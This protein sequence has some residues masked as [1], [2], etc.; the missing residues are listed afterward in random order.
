MKRDKMDCSFGA[1]SGLDLPV[2]PSIFGSGVLS[3][4]GN[5]IRFEASIS[6]SW[7][8]EFY[9]LACWKVECFD[10]FMFRGLHLIGFEFRWIQFHISSSL[11]SKCVELLSLL[12]QLVMSLMI[13]RSIRASDVTSIEARTQMRPKFS[14]VF[15]LL[16]PSSQQQM[17]RK[18]AFSISLLGIK[19]ALKF[20]FA[21]QFWLF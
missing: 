14:S 12:L 5:G 16:L 21:C 11:A 1:D 10:L 2:I 17:K 4:S 9:P 18:F 13:F 7:M 19:F 3:L 15:S 8:L 6:F 20:R